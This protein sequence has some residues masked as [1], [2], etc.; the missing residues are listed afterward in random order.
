MVLVTFDPKSIDWFY[1]KTDVYSGL[2]SLVLM[3][4][5][6]KVY[7]T[8]MSMKLHLSNSLVKN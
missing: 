7:N 5:R 4:F 6:V 1:T 3:C 2:G 8:T